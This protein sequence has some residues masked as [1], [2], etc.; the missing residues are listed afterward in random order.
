MSGR[1]AG[2]SLAYLALFVPFA[3]FFAGEGLPTPYS[4][5]L[6]PLIVLASPLLGLLVGRP[7]AMLVP[8]VPWFVAVLLVWATAGEGEVGRGGVTILYTLLFAALTLLVGLGVA[9]RIAFRRG[10]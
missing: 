7:A 8:A 3:I 5:V 4:A 1:A 6:G 2:V 10:R 9:A